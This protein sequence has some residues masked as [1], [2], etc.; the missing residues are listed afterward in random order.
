MKPVR[1]SLPLTLSTLVITILT[2]LMT[3][4]ARADSVIFHDTTDTVTATTSASDPTNPR[5][6]ISQCGITTP[7]P[8]FATGLL[9]EACTAT[10][11]A[12]SGATG[13][14]L[15]GGG[16]MAFGE[17]DGTASDF[18]AFELSLPTTTITFF[19][20]T[21]AGIPC[22]DFFGGCAV[23]EDGTVQSS[24]TLTW[25]DNSGAILATDNV[26]FQSDVEVVPEPASLALLGSGL[27]A[28]IGYTRRRRLA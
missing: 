5:I 1:H 2:T 23:T 25:L 6:T 8:F 7:D 14:N 16:F 13:L 11:S 9:L 26:S 12:P 10:L 21:S 17:G 20:D 3:A 28:I 22:S 27:L 24:E 4:P 19:S 15:S 18:I